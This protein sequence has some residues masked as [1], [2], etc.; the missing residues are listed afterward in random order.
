MKLVKSLILGSAA[1]LVAMSGAQAAD[2][3]VKA[4]AVEY[5]RICSLYGAGFYYIPGT[6]TCLKLGGYL[7]ADV[8]FN[9]GTQGTE[10]Y[11]GDLGQGNRY[12]SYFTDRSR[13]ALTVDTR[14]ATE[15]GVVR[16]FGQV[17][18]QF[19]TLGSGNSTPSLFATNLGNNTILD[20]AGGGSVFAETAFIQFA[21]FTFGRSQSVFST[22][23]AGFPGNIQSN[24][25]GSSDSS[26]GVNN[27]QY[28]W[29]FGNGVS[30]SLGAEAPIVQDRTV[31]WNQSTAAALA[32]TYSNA[33]GGQHV[34]DFAGNVKVDQAWGMFQLSGSVHNVT[35]SYNTLQGTTAGLAGTGAAVALT[36]GNT[37]APTNLSQI[38]GHPSDK[39]GGSVMA[40]LQIKN[41]PTGPGDDIKFSATWTK[42]DIHNVIATTGTTPNYIMYGGSGL[43]GA[44]GSLAFGAAADGAYLPVAN[45]GDGS[46]HLTTGYGIQGAYNHNWNPNWVTSLYG[47]MAWVRY[48]ATTQANFCASYAG[49]V[50]GQ[51]TTYTCNPNY[52]VSQ[53]GVRTGW[54][55]VKD[56]TF[57]AE[58]SWFHLG[59]GFSGFG[60]ITSS[61]LAPLPSGTYQ[62]KNQNTVALQLRAQRNF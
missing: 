9:G 8:T 56:L 40:A 36:P 12:R 31:L 38:S 32:G 39:F 11:S 52:N 23:W 13:L 4:K 33:Y 62:F 49:T 51:G 10:A 59:T 15:Y 1:G 47:G 35:A 27:I 22:P 5:V 26:T 28:T 6:D 41:I 29:Q 58:A 21:G 46:I 3:P 60:G 34:P 30:A 50:T 57:T 17:D 14:T 7:R 54:T 45:G 18:I 43:P 44:A 25:V 24:L 19:S 2:L 42:G 16:T 53:L 61:S 48:D 20:T 55:P 37:V